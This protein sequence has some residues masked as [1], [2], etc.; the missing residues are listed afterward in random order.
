MYSRGRRG[1]L[2]VGGI[3]IEVGGQGQSV[4]GRRGMY[5]SVVG[6]EDIWEGKG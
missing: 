6:G 1:V 2:S 3:Y 5:G 4:G